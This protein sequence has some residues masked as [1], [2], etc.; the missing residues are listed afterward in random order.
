MIETSLPY[1]EEVEQV[2]IGSLLY[3][4]TLFKSISDFLKADHFVNS[5]HKEIFTAIERYYERDQIADPITLKSYFKDHP[6]SKLITDYL[7]DLAS[8]AT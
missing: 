3:N 2:L 6:N 5:H 4:N 8:I 1:N 7:I